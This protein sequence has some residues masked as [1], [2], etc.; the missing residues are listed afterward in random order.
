MGRFCNIL[1]S[2]LKFNILNELT[3]YKRQYN[4]IPQQC[5]KFMDKQIKKWLK[6][7]VRELADTG[8]PWNH[9]LTIALRK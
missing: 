4:P 7:G 3:T 8:S 2:E 6:E 9:P 5:Q 1:G